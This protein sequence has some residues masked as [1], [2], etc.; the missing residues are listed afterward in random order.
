M[1]HASNVDNENQIN[2]PIN[3]LKTY[4]L[5]MNFSSHV[6]R[7]KITGSFYEIL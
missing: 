4:K 6:F 3:N 7:Y 1:L 2:K 5:V